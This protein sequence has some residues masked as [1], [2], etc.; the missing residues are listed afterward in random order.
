MAN[1]GSAYGAAVDAFNTQYN[2][3][4][5]Q[6]QGSDSLWGSS[7][8]TYAAPAPGSMVITHPSGA[9]VTIHHTPFIPRVAP[10]PPLTTPARPLG[11][12]SDNGPTIPISVPRNLNAPPYRPD[13]GP[14]PPPNPTP[15]SPVTLDP[16]SPEGLA[17]ALPDPN[18]INLRNWANLSPDEK[19]INYGLYQAKGGWTQSDIDAAVARAGQSYNGPRAG[20]IAPT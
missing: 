18:Q 5:G 15:P 3:Q 17:A 19:A 13:L 10:M 20:F 7:N 12:P 1:N 8:P 2:P 11:A 16:N 14:P 9:T 6:G 4:V